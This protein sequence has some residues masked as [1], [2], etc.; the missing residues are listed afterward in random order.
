M[1]ASGQWYSL[2]NNKYCTPSVTRILH[3][4]GLGEDILYKIPNRA[5]DYIFD[6]ENT[7]SLNPK[8]KFMIDG[9]GR[10]VRIP[11]SLHG[12][13]RDY[14]YPGGGYDTPSERTDRVPAPR[15]YTAKPN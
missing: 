6:I 14:A 13:Q 3:A 5:R 4:A 7:L 12:I 9:A 11:E 8:A 1:E 15:E 10:P 2:F